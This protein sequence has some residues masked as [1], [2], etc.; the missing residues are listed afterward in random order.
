MGEAG[1]EG[2]GEQLSLPGLGDVGRP[3]PLVLSASRRT[4]LPRF[5]PDEL[6]AR[7]RRAGLARAERF[8]GLVLWTRHPAALLEAPLR[9]FLSGEIENVIVNLTVTGL[10]GTH[11]EP[12]VPTTEA[13]LACI[14]PLIELLGGEPERL[15]WRFDP[16]LYQ[17]NGLDDFRRIA[18]VMAEHRVPTTTIS[19]PA[20]MSLGGSL[21]P[22]YRRAG[23][24]P[25]PGIAA[26]VGFARALVGEARARGLRLLACCQPKV[27]ARVEGLEAAACIPADL[28]ESLHPRSDA[29]FWAGGKDPR[30]RRHCNCMPSVDIGDYA[31]DRCHSGCVYCYSKAGGS[32]LE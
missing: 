1:D 32:E 6:I 28:L 31:S 20:T 9:T 3:R 17:R 14:G 15:R 24:E 30:Q 5:Y 26:K 22:R 4:D 2:G 16:L 12:K 25:W 10:G 11:I 19:F 7:V 21:I 29:F 18:D 23:I 8:A 27:V 13:S